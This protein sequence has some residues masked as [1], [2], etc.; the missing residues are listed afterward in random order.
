MPHLRI[1]EAARLV[2]VSDDTM[3]RWI[4]AAS[5]PTA[6]DNAG[7]TLVDGAHVAQLALDHASIPIDTSGVTRSARNQFVG[8]VTA[9]TTD[10]VMA[11]VEMQCGPHRVV[12]LMSSEAVREM[13]LEVGSVGVAVVKSTTVIVEMAT[14]KGT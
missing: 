1:S 3:R 11:Q 12:S 6:K 9:I 14:T 10:K 5:I 8:I 13:G 2:G 4:D 7:R